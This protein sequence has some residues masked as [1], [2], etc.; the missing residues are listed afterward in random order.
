MVEHENASKQNHG[1]EYGTSQDERLLSLLRDEV[2]TQLEQR[3]CAGYPKGTGIGELIDW[4]LQRF[5]SLLAWG[6]KTLKGVFSEQ[7]LVFMADALQGFGDCSD[8]LAQGVVFTLSDK[9]KLYPAQYEKLAVDGY[10]LLA[11]VEALDTLALYALV[12]V[13]ERWWAEGSEEHS[14]SITS[15][16]EGTDD[17]EHYVHI[18]I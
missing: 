11:K 15:F 1:S 9:V 4:Q 10:A 13:I 18:T 8:P 16:I 3:A 6:N 2:R 17:P 7:E 12:D 14:P 5:Y